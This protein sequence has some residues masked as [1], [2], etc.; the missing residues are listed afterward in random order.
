MRHRVA[1]TPAA[2]L[3]RSPAPE[4]WGADLKVSLGRLAM[5]G[6]LSKL[7]WPWPF[8]VSTPKLRRVVVVH[9]RRK[10]HKVS[11]EFRNDLKRITILLY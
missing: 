5:G 1:S 8:R 3:L 10:N 7:P 4:R 6:S 2:P 9:L 11:I